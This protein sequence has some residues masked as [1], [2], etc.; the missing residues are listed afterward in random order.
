[1]SAA[2][3]FVTLLLSIPDVSRSQPIARPATP[4]AGAPLA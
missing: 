4:D 3:R 1:V 2:V